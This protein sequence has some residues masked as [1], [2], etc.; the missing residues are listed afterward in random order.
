MASGDKVW[1]GAEA[2]V[3]GRPMLVRSR[4]PAGTEPDPT[5][6]NLL[7]VDLSYPIRDDIQLPSGQDY[8]LIAKFEAQAFDAYD[9]VAD[10][11][12]VFVETGAGRIRYYCYASDL[13]RAMD[14]IEEASEGLEALAF[15]S[16]EDPQWLIYRDRASRLRFE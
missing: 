10:P 3:D 16:T 7:V 12:L 5:R 9:T 6:P 11:E 14:L 2:T 4:D 13:E 1:L 8:G 15:S